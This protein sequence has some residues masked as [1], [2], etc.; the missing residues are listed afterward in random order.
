[1]RTWLVFFFALPALAASPTGEIKVDQAGY[2]PNAPKIA[3]VVSG[4]VA[5]EFLVRRAGDGLVVF[6]GPLSAAALDTD[7]QDAVQTADFTR[8]TVE[9]RY[10]IEVPGIGRSWN[11]AVAPDV[12]SRVFYLALRSFY[13]Q[14]CGTAVD[15]GPEFP[16]YSHPACHLHA[17]YHASSGKTGPAAVIG[18]WHDAGDYG[19]YVV[20]SGITTGTLLWTWELFGPRIA[21]VNL[22]IPESGNG[23]PDVLNEVRWNLQWMLSMQDQDGGVW[24]KEMSEQFGGFV[25]PEKDP[26]LPFVTGTG[27]P[28]YKSS[29]A[30]ADF[31]AVMAIAGRVYAPHDAAFA[32]KSMDAARRA[33][34]WLDKY[35]DVLFRNPPG[36]HTGEYA[37]SDC[38]DE[39]LWASA[40]LWRSTKDKVYE[41]YFMTHYGEYRDTIRPVRPQD[42]QY[43]APLA[44]WTWV[45]GGAQDAAATDIRGRTQKAADEI[46]ARSARNG[47]RTSLVASDYIWGSNSLTANYGVQLVVAN[48]LH[49]DARYVDAALDNLH[50]LLG[51]NTFSL[52][53][54][55]WAGEN[56]C[57]H[58]HHRPSGADGIGAPW[59][60]LLSGGPNKDREDAVLKA[61]PN[62]PPA[63]VYVDSQDSYAS[64]EIAI[65]WNAALVFVLA[66]TLPAN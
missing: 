46:V 29:C 59:P 8:L 26:L 47:Y 13:G 60:G 63:K 54:V 30:T 44:M 56:A 20:N 27:K 52:S 15:L 32:R 37:D 61:L 24:Q 2:L 28:P 17:E 66:A 33:W 10:Y 9:G 22:H 21:K 36:V 50:Y 14:R 39:R 16:G 58:P 62:L 11:F 53:W 55:T 7:T 25:M 4:K 12:F 48:A 64:N 42:W 38:G 65:N 5:T 34:T 43:V 1:V 31:A 49:P 3:M 23:V 51:R 40:E 18:G 19:R 35:P 57:Q 41:Q 6:H 45:L